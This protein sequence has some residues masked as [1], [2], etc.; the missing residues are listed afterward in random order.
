M[1]KKTKQYSGRDGKSTWEGRATSWTGSSSVTVRSGA[2]KKKEYM[3]LSRTSS[4]DNALYSV[5]RGY[6]DKRKRK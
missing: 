4:G 5:S 1:A 6:L 3:Q 2:K